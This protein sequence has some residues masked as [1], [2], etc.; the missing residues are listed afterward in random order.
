MT[1]ATLRLLKA[2]KLQP[3]KLPMRLHT[4]YSAAGIPK[5]WTTRGALKEAEPEKRLV[6]FTD[7]IPGATMVDEKGFSQRPL[8]P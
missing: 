2:S 4:L 3:S 5:Q 6:M 8:N 7:K 1:H